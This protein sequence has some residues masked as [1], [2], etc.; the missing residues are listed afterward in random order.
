LSA[1]SRFLYS[2]NGNGTISAVRVHADGSLTVL[3]GG[4]AGLP[5]GAVGL[6]AR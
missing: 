2:R 4:V 1:G 5:T 3:G 6:A